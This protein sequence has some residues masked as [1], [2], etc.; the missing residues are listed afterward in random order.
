MV[1]IP[2]N[3]E[4]KSFRIETRLKKKYPH[5]NF[6]FLCLEKNTRGAAETINI[7][8]SKLN[9]PDESVLCLDGDNFY[10]IDILQV[11]NK[12]NKIFTIEDLNMNPIYSYI[13]LDENKNITK[14][15]EKDKISNLACIQELMALIH[16]NRYLNTLIFVLKIIYCKK[17]SFIHP[18]LL[19]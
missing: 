8:L 10:T 1:Y 6:I 18:I 19:I 15:V 5:I 7:A 12:E 14:I 4:Y 11:W 9:I 2:Y 3:K 16:I 13:K 17:E